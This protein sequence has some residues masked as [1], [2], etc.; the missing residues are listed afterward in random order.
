MLGKHSLG[1]AAG[2][3]WLSLL[4]RADLVLT[5]GVGLVLQVELLL[6]TRRVQLIIMRG[7]V[8][9][10]ET[11]SIATT[12]ILLILWLLLIRLLHLI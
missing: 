9:E 11:W 7:R 8:L 2:I 3:H 6:N 12:T 4:G 5:G 1:R 10:A